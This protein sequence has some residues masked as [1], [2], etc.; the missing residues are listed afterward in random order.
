MTGQA[1]SQLALL[2]YVSQQANEGERQEPLVRALVCLAAASMRA[3]S[4]AAAHETLKCT[5]VVFAQHL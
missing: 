4:V 1:V 5:F 2:F 3:P